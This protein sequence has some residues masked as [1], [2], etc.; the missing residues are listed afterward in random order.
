MSKS[1][2]HSCPS[3][4]LLVSEESWKSFIETKTRGDGSLLFHTYNQERFYYRERLPVMQPLV[5]PKD[6]RPQWAS[7]AGILKCL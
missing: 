3:A 4:I 1:G 6:L 2:L 7:Q 5:A